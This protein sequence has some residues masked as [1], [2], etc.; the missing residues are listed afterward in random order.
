[1]PSLE[2][3]SVNPSCA[4]EYSMAFRGRPHDLVERR[5]LQM[6][7]LPSLF[8]AREIQHAVHQAGQTLAL[9]DNRREVVGGHIRAGGSVPSAMFPACARIDVSGVFSS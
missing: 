2:I 9:A 5:V 7:G 6:I 8:D 4:S 3:V 1:V